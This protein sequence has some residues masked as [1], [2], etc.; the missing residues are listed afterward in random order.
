M[1]N[2]QLLLIFTRNPELGKVK[3]RLAKDLGKEKA[4]A[5]YKELLNHTE[6]ISRDINCDKWV[7]YSENIS[8]EDIWDNNIFDK[9]LQTGADLGERMF[10]A[11]E[12]GFN[13]GYDEIIIIGSDIYELEQKDIEEAFEKL[14]TSEAVIG[15][16][17]DGGYYL[18][19]L[20]NSFPAVFENKDWGTPSVFKDT[21]NNFK[22]LK[23][24]TVLKKLND[25]DVI[26]DIKRDSYLYKLTL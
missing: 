10:N 14:K 2:K 6:K 8:N 13:T 20:K 16:S 5:I 23:N 15:P 21:E 11:F 12:S 22:S 7:L 3:S 4:L 17:E 26:S 9:Q 25:I 18:L 1:T 19:G 24:Y